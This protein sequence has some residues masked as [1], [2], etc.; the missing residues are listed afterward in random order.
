MW[1]EGYYYYKNLIFYILVT[2]LVRFSWFLYD[3]YIFLEKENK[4]WVV[5]WSGVW[6]VG[7]WIEGR[8]TFL[9][10]LLSY[11][12]GYS[13]GVAGGKGGRVEGVRERLPYWGKW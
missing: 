9:W 11:V 2:V 8:T 1:G 10:W 3:I 4:K 13:D 12:H 5:E 6:V 7:G